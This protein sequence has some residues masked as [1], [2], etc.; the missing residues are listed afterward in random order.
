MTGH[1]PI[2]TTEF[3]ELL[4]DDDRPWPARGG[5]WKAYRPRPRGDRPQTP[6]QTSSLPHGGDEPNL[7][8][9]HAQKDR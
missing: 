1:G 6:P 9:P 8:T 2:N 5:R 4:A 7:P 3:C